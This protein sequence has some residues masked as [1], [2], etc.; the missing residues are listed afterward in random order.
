MGLVGSWGGG[1]I[2]ILLFCGD[3]SFFFFFFFFSFF[4]LLFVCVCVCHLANFSWGSL[5]KLTIW[6]N[7]NLLYIF[8]TQGIIEFIK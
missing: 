1:E 7:Q 3:K 8:Y 5:Q 6:D 4:F 2:K